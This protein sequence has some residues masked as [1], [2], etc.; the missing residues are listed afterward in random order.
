MVNFVFF[1]DPK[2]DAKGDDESNECR[3]GW[4]VLERRSGS[5]AL[6]V[7]AE[8]FVLISTLSTFRE[9]SLTDAFLECEGVEEGLCVGVPKGDK[10]NDSSIGICMSAGILGQKCDLGRLAS[11]TDIMTAASFA[12]RGSILQEAQSR[13]VQWESPH[14]RVNW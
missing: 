8:A 2:M 5:F 7:L 11:C 4:V 14:P 3:K 1:V 10:E 13:W 9:M 12:N 6:E